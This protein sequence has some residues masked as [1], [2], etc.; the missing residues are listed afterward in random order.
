MIVLPV[1]HIRYGDNEYMEDEYDDSWLKG[2]ELTRSLY[3]VTFIRGL[4]L[5]ADIPYPQNNPAR[6][7]WKVQA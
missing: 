5:L 6:P 2:V 4:T 1:V 3:P 7:Q